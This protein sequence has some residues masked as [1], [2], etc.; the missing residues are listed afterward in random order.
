MREKVIALLES[1]EAKDNISP[2]DVVRGTRYLSDGARAKMERIV[3]EGAGALPVLIEHARFL[4]CDMLRLHEQ[5]S[6]RKPSPPPKKKGML[7]RLLQKKEKQPTTVQP[8][9]VT[10]WSRRA[11][12]K[13]SIHA[14]GLFCRDQETCTAEA[15]ELLTEFS[16]TRQYD[17]F[18]D[19]GNILKT[20]G[21]TKH[22]LWRKALFS[23]PVVEQEKSDTPLDIVQAVMRLESAEGFHLVD[24]RIEGDHFSFGADYSF[25]YDF[26]RISE[27]SFAL[28]AKMN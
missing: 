14:L 25:S 26:Y 19:S 15:L 5:D 23:L 13:A 4:Y 20:L 18:D 11:Q 22:D 16:Q 2:E 8:S 24:R 7:S 21:V 17:V 1:I 12:V 6:Q 3:Q 10:Y 27:D 28:R 9:E